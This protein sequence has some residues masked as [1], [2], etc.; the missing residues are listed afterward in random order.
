MTYRV[1]VV[2]DDPMFG[3]LIKQWLESEGHDAILANTLEAG[4]VTI[5]AEPLPD[6]VLLDIYLGHKNGLTLV[7]WVRRQKHLAHIPIAAVT[8]SDCFK[9]LKSAQEAG[10]NSCFTKPIDFGT[11]REFLATLGVR[12]QPVT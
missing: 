2:E 10:C 5:A 6:V 3:E 11:L 9:D 12:H 8:G 1:L 4:F 7:H